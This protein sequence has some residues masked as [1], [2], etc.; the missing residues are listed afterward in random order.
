MRGSSYSMKNMLTSIQT[1]S[2]VAMVSMA[3]IYYARIIDTVYRN[4]R[5]H[6]R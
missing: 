3:L 1:L 5:D 4:K 2:G 6:S